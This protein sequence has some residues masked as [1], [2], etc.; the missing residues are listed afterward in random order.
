M[1]SSCRQVFLQVSCDGCCDHGP[2]PQLYLLWTRV[3]TCCLYLLTARQSSGN[4]ASTDDPALPLVNCI[5]WGP[6]KPCTPREVLAPKENVRLLLR[7]ALS[8]AKRALLICEV[9]FLKGYKPSSASITIG[10]ILLTF[11]SN[12]PSF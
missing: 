12:Y 10:F 5:S 3:G 4:V 8:K 9:I 2:D 7:L 11:L 1:A 6:P